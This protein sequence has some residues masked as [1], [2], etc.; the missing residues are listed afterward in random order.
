MAPLWYNIE[1]ERYIM[2]KLQVKSGT[3]EIRNDEA[4]PEVNVQPARR[5]S[6]QQ[7]GKN[8]QRQARGPIQTLLHTTGEG[9]KVN[10]PKK[11][12]ISDIYEP[13]KKLMLKPKFKKMP[14][15]QKMPL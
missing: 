4:G 14:Y 15:K 5:L 7:V 3:S 13:L 2:S 12:N 8:V 10:A 9:K 1:K 11:R 6:R